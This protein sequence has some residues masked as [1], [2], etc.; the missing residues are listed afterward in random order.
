MS[1]VALDLIRGNDGTFAVTITD[2]AAP[3]TVPQPVDITGATLTFEARANPTD[4]LPIITETL[5]VN[6]DQTGH[7]GQASLA[8]PAAATASLTAPAV[9]T[10][11]I[12]MVLS[13][14]TSTP[15]EGSLLLSVNAEPSGPVAC[16]LAQIKQRLYADQPV[17]SGQFDAVLTDAIVEVTDMIVQEIRQQR[18]EPEG[19]TFL[20]GAPVTRRYTGVTGGSN[21]LLIDDAISV[22]SV[23]L[24]SPQGAVQQTLMLGTDYLPYPLNSTPI[25]GLRRLSGAFWPW[26]TGSVGVGMTPGYATSWPG[27]ITAAAIL[28]VI[29]GWRAGQAGVT[30]QLG[31]NPDGTVILSK[32]LL[33]STVRMCRRY[34]AGFATLRSTS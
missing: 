15:I 12:T 18:G 30:D 19:W 26:D 21:L 13:G 24:L 5:T 32:A 25:Y 16:T 7:K 27:N 1:F 34:R 10:Y 11:A 31:I 33:D 14:A 17:M 22:S 29:R 6:P 8:I 9:L 23:T 28:E 20:P 2:G 3:P 4:T